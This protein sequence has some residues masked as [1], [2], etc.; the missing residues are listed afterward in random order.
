MSNALVGPIVE[1]LN[2]YAR[3]T[4]NMLVDARISLL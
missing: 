3:D 1:E 2:Q 4:T